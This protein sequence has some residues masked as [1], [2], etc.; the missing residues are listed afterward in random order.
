MS[1]RA[2]R[3]LLLV[4]LLALAPGAPAK[5]VAGVTIVRVFP[6]WRD[7]SSFK[8]ISEYFTGRE[9]TGGQIVLRT[10]PDERG[11]YYFLVRV[12]NPDA[13]QAVT[14]ILDIVRAGNAGTQTY[15]FHASLAAGDTV[16]NLGLTGVDWTDAK[17][18][19]VAWRVT[20]KAADGHILASDR[21]YL[22]EK[23]VGS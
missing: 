7:A 23:P 5:E 10:H 4:L 12:R 21:S 19:P 6:G 15:P 18:D 8:R 11:G 17:A 1:I 3:G 9:D 14:A 20:L 16:L 2:I 22:W 13:P